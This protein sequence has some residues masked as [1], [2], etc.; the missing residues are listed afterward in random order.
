MKNIVLV[1]ARV[2]RVFFC[3]ALSVVCFWLSHGVGSGLVLF[4]LGSVFSHFK[5]KIDLL[6]RK[7]YVVTLDH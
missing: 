1:G 5:P 3:A 2:L 4:A 6:N 7:H